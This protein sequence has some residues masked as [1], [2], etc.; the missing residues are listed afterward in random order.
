[1]S[2]FYSFSTRS[3][4]L[5]CFLGLLSLTAQAQNFTVS[6]IVRD[7]ATGETLLGANVE[8]VEKKVP[9]P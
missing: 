6:G 4:F 8:V 9:E 1:M 3:L 7:A 5:I 2:V